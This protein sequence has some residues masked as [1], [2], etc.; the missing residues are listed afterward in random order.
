[1]PKNRVAKQK[2]EFAKPPFADADWEVPASN[3]QYW[4]AVR[5]AAANSLIAGPRKRAQNTVVFKHVSKNLVTDNTERARVALRCEQ[6][7][8]ERG[9]SKE[10]HAARTI[11]NELALGERGL[12]KGTEWRA[13]ACGGA[14]RGALDEARGGYYMLSES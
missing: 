1:M 11:S 7:F 14:M 3:E 4:R 10:E 2:K 8:L 9:A 5:S 6:L 12:K 13:G